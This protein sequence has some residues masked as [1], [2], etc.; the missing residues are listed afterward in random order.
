MA[1]L[2]RYRTINIIG[3]VILLLIGCGWAAYSYSK[4]GSYIIE[5][6]VVVGVW[7]LD[8]MMKVLPVLLI[9]GSLMIIFLALVW[10]KSKMDDL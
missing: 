8:P 10:P 7:V 4:D 9:V 3:S 2:S 1:G 6:G 5:N